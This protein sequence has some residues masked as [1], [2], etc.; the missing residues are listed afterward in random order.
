[1]TIARQHSNEEKRDTTIRAVWAAIA[2]YGID[3]TTID[4]V[5]S[6]AGFS[7]G[8]IHYYFDSKK[9][10]LLAAFAAFLESFDSEIFGILGSLGREPDASEALE[11]VIRS[12]LPSFSPEDGLA[13]ELPIPNAGEI[14][15]PH[16]KARL[17]V[18][19]FILAMGDRDFAAVVARSYE[20]QGRAVAKCLETLEPKAPP[21]TVLAHAAALMALID[22]FSLHRVLGYAPAG[23]GEHADITRGFV[24]TLARGTST[25]A[26]SS[27]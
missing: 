17:F 16:Y 27:T 2:R 6:L 7:K 18:Q 10:L 11:A 9:A 14:L 5:A 26:G 13:A 8:V 4:C 24:E 20:R 23:L 15:S 22:G 12:T 19:F 21:E 3:G 1:M 25:P